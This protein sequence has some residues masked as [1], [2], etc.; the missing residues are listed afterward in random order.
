MPVRVHKAS[1]YLK[2][3]EDI[4]AYL[5]A[6]IE[7]FNG[8]PRLLMKAFHNVAAAQGGVTELARRADKRLEL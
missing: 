3:P 2:P 5:N 7:E 6:T 4:A 1:D 8:N